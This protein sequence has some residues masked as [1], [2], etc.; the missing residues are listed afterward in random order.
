MLQAWDEFT[1]EQYFGLANQASHRAESDAEICGEILCRLL[2]TAAGAIKEEIAQLERSTPSDAELEVCAVIQKILVDSGKDISLLGFRKNSS[3]YVDVSFLY[4]ILKFKFAK[5][6]RYIILDNTT[7]KRISLPQEPCSSSE[8]GTANIRIYFSNPLDLVPLKESIIAAY[9]KLKDY[10]NEIVIIE[11]F[12]SRGAYGKD[13]RFEARRASAIK[14]LYSKQE[15][16]RKEIEKAIEKEK[17]KK[18][19]EEKAQVKEKVQRGRAICQLDDAG[20]VIAV[21]DSLSQAVETIGVSSKSIRD[22]ANG[23]QK[24][25]GGFCWKYKDQLEGQ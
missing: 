10:D 25:A 12:L 18:E 1:I 13:G 7:P 14:A 23:V 8:G 17:K 3:G 20:N 6:G 19:K 22:A 5:K 24:H 11:E 16:E 2:A 21:Y 9:E 15:A 4:A